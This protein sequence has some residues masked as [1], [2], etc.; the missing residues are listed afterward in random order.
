M[1]IAKILEDRN[2]DNM[3]EVEYEGGVWRE[4][5]FPF[6]GD[7]GDLRGAVLRGAATIFLSEAL[8]HREGCRVGR[9]DISIDHNFNSRTGDH[10]DIGPRGLLRVAHGTGCFRIRSSRPARGCRTLRTTR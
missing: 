4:G 9:D 8:G 1:C 3:A 6:P 2:T 5:T 7:S 10:S